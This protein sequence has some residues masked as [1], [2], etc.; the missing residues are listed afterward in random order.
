MSMVVGSW[1]IIQS[2]LERIAACKAVY[3][4]VL[5][6]F[7]FDATGSHGGVSRWLLVAVFD[8]KSQD[9]TRLPGG[10]SR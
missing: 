10:G 8:K 9:A 4:V 7:G 1:P 2:R 5:M 6:Q 3:D